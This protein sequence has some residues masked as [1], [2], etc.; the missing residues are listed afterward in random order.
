M[1]VSIKPFDNRI[2]LHRFFIPISLLLTCCSTAWA[3]RLSIP[4]EHNYAGSLLFNVSLDHPRLYRLSPSDLNAPYVHRFF[5]VTTIEGI[6]Y[7]KRQLRCRSELLS[8]VLPTPVNLYIESKTFLIDGSDQ[9]HLTLIPIH[10]EFEHETC[11]EIDR[12]QSHLREF[13]QLSYFSDE[14]YE[15]DYHDYL[16][17]ES[18]FYN[19]PNRHFYGSLAE[20][21]IE[22]NV[23]L[24]IQDDGLCVDRYQFLTRLPKFVSS[25]VKSSCTSYYHVLGATTVDNI[26]YDTNLEFRIEHSNQDLISTKKYCLPNGRS[27]D[28]HIGLAENVSSS[29]TPS[30]S[31][32]FI[33]LMSSIERLTLTFYAK[34]FD[35]E[36]FMSKLT[37]RQRQLYQS[38][39]QSGRSRRE[40]VSS[41]NSGPSFDRSL[42]I[43]SVPEEREK[44]FVVTQLVATPGRP[45]ESIESSELLYSMSA[46]ID[47]RSQSMFAIDPVSGL[48]TT[49]TRL[50]REFMD[51]HYLRITVTDG[52]VP[53]RTASTTLQINVLDEN[54]HVPVFEHANY[55]SSLRE[56]APLGT[57][58]LTIRATDHDSGPNAEI[59]YSI[60]NPTGVNEA[61]RIDPKHGVITSRTGLDRE[62][63][64]LYT[65]TVQA[66]DSGAV[67]SRKRSHTTV[68]IK[69]LDENDN[70]PQFAER[71]YSVSVDEDVN[72]AS[73]PVIIR[74]VAHD[75]DE[76]L[77]A[78]IR[79]S[80]IGG[81]TAA[82]FHIDSLNG[83]VA[84]VGPLDYETARSYRL[85]IRA[86]DGGSPPRSNTTQLL[87]SV[88]DKNDNEPRF[89]TTL[90]QENV[91]ENVPV[92]TSVVRVQAYDADDGD[93]AQLSYHIQRSSSDENADR[94][95]ASMP[96]DIDLSS[97]W[98]MTTRELDREEE[99]LYEFTVIARDNGYPIQ[100][101]ASALVIIQVQDLNDNAPVFEPRNY[102][103]V[104]SETATPGTPI[105][106]VTATDRDENSRL[107]FQITGGNLRNRFAIVSQNNQG[108][109]TVANPLDYKQEKNYVLTVSATDPGGKVDLA[110]V[111]INVTD[112]NTHR[113]VIQ[114]LKNNGSPF[115]ATLTTIAEDAPIGTT[116][117]V[118]EAIDDDVG[119]N[120]R[121][122]YSLNEVPEF[123]IDPNS[124]AI[125]T[126]KA[127]DRET[128][129][130]YTLIVTAQDNGIPP[131]SDIANIEIEVIDVNDNVPLFEQHHYSATVMEDAP[132]GTS[133]CQVRASD[134]D[135]GLNGQVRYEFEMIGN[136]VQQH[137]HQHIDMEFSPLGVFS[138]DATSGVIRTN[139]TLDR[140]TIAKYDLK[141]VAFDRGTPSLSSSVIVHVTIEDCNDNPPRF[142]SDRLRFYVPENSPIGS[143]VGEL[144]ATD[145][146][147]GANARIEYTIVGGSDMK[148]FALKS[149]SSSS[150]QQSSI[151]SSSSALDSS[152]NSVATLITRTE[153][154]FESEKKVYNII[155]RASS[156]P[157]RNDVDVEIHVTDVNDHAPLLRDFAIIFNN[158]RGHFPLGQVIGRV[159]AYDADIGDHL[160]HRFIAGN[161]A[162]LLLLNETSGELRLSPSLNTNVP[163]RA[164]LEVAVSDGVNE[165]IARCYLAVNLVTESMLFHSVTVRLNR[166][167]RH[168][169]LSNLYDRFLDGLATVI[170]CAKENIIIFNI[171]DDT[172]SE[173]MPV[174]NVSFSARLSESLRD[175][176]SYYS[177]QF[178]QERVYI[179]RTLL[180][181]LTGLEVLP[182]DDNLC[183]REPC[184]NFE[185]CLSVL[186]FGNA[187]DFIGTEA[188]LFRSI[189]PVNTFACRCPIGF[190]GMHHKYECDIEINLCFSNPC[191]NGGQCVRKEGGYYCDCSDNFAGINCEINVWTDICRTN[192]CRG[193]SKCVSPAPSML[194]ESSTNL[195]EQDTKSPLDSSITSNSSS[196]ANIRAI[197]TVQPQQQEMVICTDCV[198]SEWSTPFCEL[199]S[200]SF[201]TGSYLIF[202]ALKQ[203][204]RLNLKLRFATRQPNG[205][206]LYNGRYNELHDFIGLE[207]IDGRVYFSFSLGGV[208]R[209]QVSVGHRLND[210]QWHH[211]QLNYVNHTATL[212][213]DNCDEA[214]LTAVDRYDLGP[215]FACANRTTLILESRCS[216]RMQT[217]FRF[218]DLTGPLQIG[219]LPPLPTEFQVENTDFNG[220][221]SDLRID[222]NLVDF[223]SYVA[224]NGTIIGCPSK[225][226]FCNTNSCNGRGQCED[227][228]NGY[229]CRC[230]NGYTGQDCLILTDTVRHFK[231][232]GFLS[233]T[234]NLQPL[235]YPWLVSF[236]MHTSARNAIIVAIQL[237]QSSMVRFEVIG[238]KLS[239]GVDD[240]TPI[241]IED[242]DINDG[243]WHHVE[244]RWMAIGITLSVD[245][246]Q[247]TKRTR[248]DG[249]EILGLYIAKVTVGGHD[250]PD[251]ITEAYTYRSQAPA[252]IGCI[253]SLDV[254]NSK[255]SW[256]RPTLED[257]VFV[258][259]PTPSSSGNEQCK[260]DPCPSNS[261]C[262]VKGIND[263]EC[264]CHIGFMGKNCMPICELNP[265]SYG[266]TCVTANNTYGYRCLCDRFHSGFYCE[267]LLP[268]TC[269]VDWW[270]SPICGPC[271]CDAT[272]GYDANCNKTTGE[273][274][275]QPNRFQPNGSDECF[276]C[277]CY[278]TGSYTNRCDRQT[279]QCQCRLGVIG[280][281]CDK[282]PSP[283][284]EVTNRGCEVIYDACPRAFSDGIW[285]ERTPF[286][287]KS[288]RRCPPFST[289]MAHRF[290]RQGDGWLKP[291]LFECL[292]DPFLD[293]QEQWKIITDSDSQQNGSIVL[294]NTQHS[295]RLVNDLRTA[296]NVT[297]SF[298]DGD[299]HLVFRLV[300]RL[301]QNE[302]YQT[303]LNLTHK[304][305]RHFLRN[306]CESTSAILDPRYSTVWERIADI[307]V[308][309][310]QLLKLFNQYAEVLINNQ[311]D[312]FT[313]P[314]EIATK[315]LV[316]GLDTVATHELWDLSSSFQLQQN[317]FGSHDHKPLS[318][319]HSE[320][321]PSNS[322]SSIYLDFSLP[323]DPLITSN[324]D[325]EDDNPL[326]QS[327]PSV[328]IPK[329]NNY[330]LRKHNIDDIT[331]AIIPLKILNVQSFDELRSSSPSS[332]ASTSPTSLF[333]PQQQ[334]NSLIG[335]TIFTSMAQFLPSNTDST[336]RQRFSN[337]IKANTPIVILTI[338]PFNS[339]AQKFL[340]KSLHPKIRFRFRMLAREGRSSPQ[341]VYWA[342]PTS[343]S[344]ATSGV[345]N[346]RSSSRGRWSSKGC[347]LK[348]F[349]PPQRFRTSYDYINCSCDRAF[350]VA[351]LMDVS[352]DEFYYEES[353]AQ[354]ATSYTLTITSL[355]LLA[356]TLII[357]S[358]VRGL[359]TNSNSIHKN[360]VFCLF[361]TESMFLLAVRNRT[362]LVQ[363]ESSCKLVAIF[364]HYS[365]QCLFTWM[366]IESIHLYRMLTE[367]RDINRGPMR[368]YYFVGYGVAAIIVALSVGV[369]ADQYGNHLFCFISIYEGVIWGL[370]TPLCLIIIVNLFVF[371]LAIQASAQFKASVCD[372]GNLR[373]LLW[374]SIVLVPLLVALW[375]LALLSINDTIDELHHGY[376]LMTLIC[377]LYIFIAY[378]LAN[379]RVRFS[380]NSDWWQSLAT[381]RA[382]P[383]INGSDE[384]FS[385]TR[386]SVT[387]RNGQGGY[388]HSGSTFDVYG[389]NQPSH[390]QSI[391]QPI[392]SSQ[393]AA[394]ISSS[395][396][397]SRSTLTKGS[398]GIVEPTDDDQTTTDLM[399]HHQQNQINQLIQEQQQHTPTGGGGGIYNTNAM[400]IISEPSSDLSSSAPTVIYGQHAANNRSSPAAYVGVAKATPVILKQTDDGQQAHLITTSLIA[401]GRSNL[402][403]M[404]AGLNS[405]GDQPVSPIYG[406]HSISVQPTEHIYSYA[407]K[408][409]QPEQPS[410]YSTLG[411][412]T[413]SVNPV[414]KPM[415]DVGLPPVSGTTYRPHYQSI[416]ENPLKSATWSHVRLLQP[417]SPV[418]K[419]TE[420][421]AVNSTPMTNDI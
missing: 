110:T 275:C 186:K 39:H 361:M 382:R 13:T 241:V 262:I 394:V 396:T 45:A 132:I 69:I 19:E 4:S 381:S 206:L 30:K 28:V 234:P 7:I 50:D 315:W 121:I 127:L 311:R 106:I 232:N 119:E 167:T 281:R 273:C 49:T 158:Y 165:A 309:P 90:F 181:E 12:H 419:T 253:Q 294:I 65:L 223:D 63:N 375:I 60:L 209:A 214:L 256:L 3:L 403:A 249:A 208:N 116:V 247:Y 318:V 409:N 58:V 163:T 83:E 87:I 225:K 296:I 383:C 84:V 389:L 406:H 327:N 37:D 420:E 153:L 338:K 346:R 413:A 10:I 377:A 70:Y 237:G 178:L 157:L 138:I 184:L 201:V 140:E 349:Y 246:G 314:F 195:L 122:T 55:E 222:H 351:V 360:I 323:P 36:E 295:I 112:A 342:F 168:R 41:I 149:T 9:N 303:G 352:G 133:V 357:L 358:L 401:A 243:K 287:S 226:S 368:F 98:I 159:P 148:W 135:L 81:N 330:P 395:S 93:N 337:P 391:D 53:P 102:E 27:F 242:M 291:D 405:G 85:V 103:A 2:R 88:L 218:L 220:C 252:F 68:G 125:T 147:E 210:G 79:Y 387:S 72:Y 141:V 91:M 251:E 316:F 386:T 18:L 334:Q 35:T 305:D 385:A 174:L 32:T 104:I 101:S 228:W 292:S 250:T 76:G 156:L 59:E 265:C 128:T 270:G 410:H 182:F 286:G 20:P 221:I 240:R 217:C 99:S 109:L 200:R 164:L 238:G 245:Y 212:I 170:P 365:F 320:P 146:D 408:S 25:Y 51:V 193:R 78:A 258:G 259:C 230:E 345:S 229:V 44:S 82:L 95:A 136:D 283:F 134:R 344:V 16:N 219:G 348:G 203:R 89:Y 335:Y 143:V 302:L 56:S 380:L 301:I 142:A 114:I 215:E 322:T 244:A 280:R 285:W 23:L 199:R 190:Q 161:K 412:A 183:V 299:V 34:D 260:S 113:P 107:V 185:E 191:Q 61:F 278:T 325:R 202:S 392:D 417:S 353:M 366:L 231:G 111:Y 404:T 378:C 144:R 38:N 115:S 400:N 326:G 189:S 312:T 77:N 162:N 239:Y 284:A 29:A 33:K 371:M 347:E 343:T 418:S 175:T 255:E 71:S 131:L 298:Y 8:E 393:M 266:S 331:K 75:A 307:D 43:V 118:V 124:G 339:S 308:G 369:R 196:S 213:L 364:L 324:T 52:N 376:S 319:R 224:N 398:T 263:H 15:H 205:L 414:I 197:T 407:R 290:C 267:D 264:R 233:F 187:S 340:T 137:Q 388:Y 293:L 154:D 235:A 31:S 179:S 6:L 48:V 350:G 216:D 66:S 415:D 257:N 155:V 370:V 355:V 166:I 126:V 411:P 288:T 92:G 139:R 62:K 227:A 64:D 169:F 54:D 321:S 194:L 117:L 421:T 105:V 362:S 341:C 211:V 14:L 333:K 276:L 397:T 304:Q 160:R 384:S 192:L 354:I 176:E 177:S 274:F 96:I 46:L 26:H 47:A 313:E 367:I 416:K 173:L 172:E 80:I 5:D 17:P 289:G 272:K 150:Q 86:Q 248:L 108:H 390:G 145:A 254:G 57:T 336:V 372:Y 24:T 97:G 198:Q 152:I 356:L 11:T 236:D 42:Y 171:Q 279:G 373:T 151:S 73:R 359:D 207:L 269:P 67:Q 297:D 332:S 379:R 374:L 300:R 306:L 268:E 329:Y 188:I 1:A 399:Q 180:T 94:T 277:D 21:N 317:R 74:I 271:N 261:D 123:R 402:M 310:E 328:V 40:T 22:T 129:A 130:G 100:H 120:A 363:M 204:Y 282:C